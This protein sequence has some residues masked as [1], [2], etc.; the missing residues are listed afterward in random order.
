M[1]W[2]IGSLPC[3]W[4]GVR[5]TSQTPVKGMMK[6]L[7]DSNGL[8]AKLLLVISGSVIAILSLLLALVFIVTDA[9]WFSATTL[10]AG[11]AALFITIPW[12]RARSMWIC[13]LALIANCVVI[14]IA[15]GFFTLLLCALPAS[16]IVLEACT[17]RSPLASSFVA[18]IGSLLIGLLLWFLGFRGMIVQRRREFM[19]EPED[20]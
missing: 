8:P 9:R 14:A 20:G 16:I 11:L 12:A 17:P 5:N 10:F 4:S 18:L 13:D 7:T 15:T 6:R 19:G 3:W 1:L 2:W